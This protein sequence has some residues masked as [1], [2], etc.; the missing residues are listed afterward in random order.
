MVKMGGLEP[1]YNENFF[2]LLH[3]NLLHYVACNNENIGFDK[4]IDNLI[5]QIYRKISVDILTK[6][7]R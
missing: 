5:L 1:N 4:Y 7:Y 3:I 6:K 2:L